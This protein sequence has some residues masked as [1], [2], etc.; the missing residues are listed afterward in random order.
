MRFLG[1]W[2][3]ERLGAARCSGVPNLCPLAAGGQAN[4]DTKAVAVV[5]NETATGITSD[6]QRVRETMDDA[7]SDALLLVHLLGSPQIR[8]SA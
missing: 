1:I 7:G 2:L 6:L 4:K 3:S 8:P 5:H